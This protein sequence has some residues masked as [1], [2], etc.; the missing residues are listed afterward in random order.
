M[1]EMPIGSVE[2]Q[3]PV[4]PIKEIKEE[5]LPFLVTL[6]MNYRNEV[7][8]VMPHF[9]DPEHATY[10]CRVDWFNTLLNTLALFISQLKDPTYSVVQA[11][12]DGLRA[13]PWKDWN[14]ITRDDVNEANR[15][16][17]MVINYIK[18]EM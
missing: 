8:A 7:P 2:Q 17:V 6:H 14:N 1:P 3:M 18:Q 13:R 9:S 10:K 5:L 15:I 12:Y 4:T 16:L 11:Y